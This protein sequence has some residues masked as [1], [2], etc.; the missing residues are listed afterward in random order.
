MSGVANNRTVNANPF[1]H[2]GIQR[3]QERIHGADF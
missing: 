1:P 3:K 2:L